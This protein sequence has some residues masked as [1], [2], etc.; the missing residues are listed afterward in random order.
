MCGILFSTNRYLSQKCFQNALELMDHRGPDS[1]KIIN[2]DNVMLGHTRLNVL[3]LDKRSD[4]PLYSNNGRYV[5]IFNGEIYNY[6]ELAR[7]Y[8]I[9]QRTNGDTELLIELYI[10][11]GSRMLSELNGMFAFLIYDIKNNN[12][13]VARDRL[14]V[15]PLYY[16]YYKGD[17][18]LASEVASLL[19]MINDNS[20]DRLGIRQ[21][22]KLRSFFNGRTMYKHIKSFPS[23]FYMFNNKLTQYWK[24][25]Q[26]SQEAPDP[27][28]LYDLLDTS[29]KYRCISDVPVGSYLSGGLDSSLITSMS[30][31]KHS[32]TVG[33]E[34]C[35]EF[36]WS[37]K[38]S[39]LIGTQ[40]NETI[41]NFEEFKKT[42]KWM[43]NKRK[44]PLSVP[45]EVLLYEMT[46]EVRK[47]NTV[48]LSGEG[49]DELYFGYD[50]IFKYFSQ[51]EFEVSAFD[52]LYSYGTN[53]DNEIID[54][55]L[56]P[57]ISSGLSG[58]ELVAH[59]FQ[60]AH[61]QGLLRRL[62]NSTML[63]SVEARVPFTDYRLVERLAGV[64]F[65]H[66]ITN[67]CAK[68]PLKQLAKKM[69]ILSDDIIY[70]KKIGFPVPLDRIFSNTLSGTGENMDNW[71]DFNLATL[72]VP[73][74]KEY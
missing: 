9:N 22:R 31:V 46:K 70:R 12:T 1:K 73:F 27:E 4:Q 14:G 24:L 28:E 69:G 47:K 60:V 6:K 61:L 72:G 8:N 17:F 38:A 48:V 74:E 66:R 16:S 42:A 68:Y 49:A 26:G 67:G 18:Y 30:G 5:V 43:I 45:N 50:K 64:D 37:K 29:I 3:D 54:D 57:F 19:Y 32:W 33:F 36:N 35:N 11:L 10:K 15:K 51:N 55:V 7:K 23:G 2:I 34:S 52:K 65:N 59:F 56:E 25:L 44:E 63:C 53:N 40:H 20:I 62:D 71:L 13:F 41:I 39:S 58:L 21:Y